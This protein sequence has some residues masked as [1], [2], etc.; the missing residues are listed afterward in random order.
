MVVA[1]L[2]NGTVLAEHIV[3]ADE[4]QKQETNYQ[5]NACHMYTADLTE[6]LSGQPVNITIKA[7]GDGIYTYDSDLANALTI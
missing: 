7:L 1:S 3:F 5:G 2:Q 6:M 4:L